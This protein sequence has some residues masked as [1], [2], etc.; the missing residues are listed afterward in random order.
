MPGPCLWEA[1]SRTPENG[2]VMGG[3][4]GAEA[5]WEVAAEGG[6]ICGGDGGGMLRVGNEGGGGGGSRGPAQVMSSNGAPVCWHREFS[7]PT[8]CGGLR[9]PPSECRRAGS[10]GSG[11]WFRA[12]DGG[13]GSGCEFCEA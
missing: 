10:K 6:G 8:Y 5:R 9:A 12:W 1:R 3:P 2:E 13:G 11:I 7:P 4:R